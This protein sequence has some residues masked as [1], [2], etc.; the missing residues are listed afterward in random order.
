MNQLSDFLENIYFILPIVRENSS[1]LLAVGTILI[2]WVLKRQIL[3]QNQKFLHDLK[4]IQSIS[5]KEI[6]PQTTPPPPTLPHQSAAHY[7]NLLENKI[8]VYQELMEIKN[9]FLYTQHNLAE[10]GLTAKKYYAFFKEFRD[11]VTHNRLYL[12][13]ETDAIFS[14]IMQESSQYLF[15]IKHLESEFHEVAS[16]PAADRYILEQLI[17]QETVVLEKFHQQSYP[18]M[19]QFMDMIDNDVAQIRLRLDEL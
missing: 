7:Q 12:V 18:K 2:V 19:E 4:Q 6:A 16:Q 15:K 8:N 11:L 3:R 10:N 14:E 17:E 9:E 13:S 5:T 1:I